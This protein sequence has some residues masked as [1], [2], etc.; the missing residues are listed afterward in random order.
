[1]ARKS[2]ADMVDE[3]T[4]PEAPMIPRRPDVVKPQS[5]EATTPPAHDV[6]TSDS[7]EATTSV[8]HDVVTPRRSDVEAPH[9]HEV[10]TSGGSD[11]T[12]PERPAE[13]TSEPR[14][15]TTSERREARKPQRRDATKSRRN[16]APSVDESVA[17]TVRFDPAEYLDIEEWLIGLRRELGRSRLDKSEV[18]RALFQAARGNA[19]VRR[20]LIATLAKP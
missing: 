3:V 14:E 13:A 4:P 10:A 2:I 7:Q 8:A 1:M 18:V 17:L 9:S 15:T 6:T 5:Q 12:T 16:T 20:A 11:A 19:A